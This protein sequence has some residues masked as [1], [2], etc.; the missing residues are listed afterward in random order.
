MLLKRLELKKFPQV[1]SFFNLSHFLVAKLAKGKFQ[2]NMEFIQWLYS[3]AVKISPNIA[4]FY[5]GYERRLESYMRQ[6]GGKIEFKLF[7]LTENSSRLAG[8]AN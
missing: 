4:K 6:N 2:D 7:E 3:Y 5:N 8:G 1:L